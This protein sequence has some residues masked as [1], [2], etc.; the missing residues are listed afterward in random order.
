M[1]KLVGVDE[2]LS[3]QFCGQGAT[4]KLLRQRAVGVVHLQGRLLDMMGTTLCADQLAE[5][6]H[7]L[8][9]VTGAVETGQATALVDETDKSAHYPRIGEDLSITAVHKHRVVVENLGIF[10]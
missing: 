7:V 9:C 1:I 4:G 8:G 2:A 5:L 6:R 10:Q 3:P